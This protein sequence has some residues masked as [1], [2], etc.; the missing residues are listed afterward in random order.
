MQKFLFQLAYTPRTWSTQVRNRDSML[1]QVTPLLGRCEGHLD[2]C[3]FALGDVDL[4]MVADFAGPEGAALFSLAATA[5]G[6]SVKTTALLTTEQTHSAMRRAAEAMAP[7][8]G[9][10]NLNPA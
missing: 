9:V 2:S 8:N 6:A 3:F 7:R 1:D 10:V 5:Q 4:I